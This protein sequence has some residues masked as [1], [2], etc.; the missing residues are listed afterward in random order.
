L[1]YPGE[2]G[3]QLHFTGQAKEGK[4]KGGIKEEWKKQRVQI[5]V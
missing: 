4:P 5:G 1:K 3:K 2:I